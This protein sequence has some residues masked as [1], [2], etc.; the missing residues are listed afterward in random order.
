MIVTMSSNE[1]NKPPIDVPINSSK[2]DVLGRAEVAHDFAKSIR[3]LDAS[4]GIVIGVLGNWG[5][6]KSSFVNLMREEFRNEPSLTVVDFNPWMFSGTQ[7]LIDVFFKEVSSELRLKDKTK[8]GDIA[9]SMLEY[10]D[11][12]SPVAMIPVVGAYFDRSIRALKTMRKW[13]K[14]RSAT[15]LR[16]KVTSAL[17]ELEQP[18]VVVIDDIDRLSTSEIRDIFKLV[19]LTASFPNI[20]YV[21]SFDRKRVEA[22]LDEDNVP[23]RQYLEKIIQLSFDLPTMPNELMRGEVFKKLD[24]VLDGVDNVR[25]SQEEWPHIYFEV[26]EPL[27]TNLRD[28]TR[29]ALSAQ[30]AVETLGAEVET[31]DILALE[32]IRVFRPELFEQIQNM[33]ATL[34]GVSEPSFRDPDNEERKAEVD[35]LLEVAGKDKEV[36]EELIRYVFPAA[37]RYTNNVHYGYDSLSSWKREHRV[38]HIDF[39]NM[40]FDRVAPKGLLAFRR[41]ERAISFLSEP[42]GFAKYL[43][44]LQPEE[45]ET[46]IAGL[47][48]YEGEYAIETIAPACIALMNRVHAIPDRAPTNIFDIVRPDM[49]VGRVVLRMLRT[50]PE[51]EGRENAVKDILTGIVSYSS[52]KDFI[53]LV[54]YDEG[55]G[56]KLISKELWEHLETEFFAK[57]AAQQS[58]VPK[59]EW[60][61]ANVYLSLAKKQGD[62]FQPITLRSIDAIRSLFDSAVSTATSETSTGVKQERRLWWEGL[63]TIF[64]SE[65]KIKKAV[66]KLR[67]ADGDTE[68][69]QLVDKY[70]GGWRPKR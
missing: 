35:K 54:G 4:E 25:F 32:A 61:L 23:G 65:S 70:L 27:I 15:P 57:V 64:G 9:D 58:K 36:V 17:L 26:I 16:N 43:D 68:L 2:E 28:V 41:S 48:A 69:V 6:G 63:V 40:Y 31:A 14:E 34:T 44:S 42:D 19:R 7:Q 47:E 60:G 39:L 53:Q 52:Q 18:I 45:L 67:K 13:W 49:V 5:S 12:V 11:A 51:G 33:R 37:R 66:D 38:A 24:V 22:A 55:S 50:I 56:H 1:Q 29:L 21:L 3:R 10:S 30:L 46:T 62:D 59:Q 20:I 8:F